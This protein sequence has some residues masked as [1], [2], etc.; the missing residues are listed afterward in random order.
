VKIVAICLMAILLSVPECLAALDTLIEVARSQGA[1]QKQ[2]ADETRVF[3][4][5]KKGVESGA[6]A[7]GKSK[8]AIIAEYGKP[9]VAVKNSDGKREDCIYKPAAS[10]FFEG[11]RVTLTF[12]EQGILEDALIE[13]GHAHPDR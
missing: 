4:R 7:K 13:D 12:T 2:Y 6:I 10:S 1:I 11:I 9:V 8:S 3:E 5:V